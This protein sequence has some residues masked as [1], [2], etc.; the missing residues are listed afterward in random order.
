MEVFMKT[1][2]LIFA[3]FL[4]IFLAVP[5]TPCIETA[6][7]K[8]TILYDNYVYEKGLSADWG[9]SCLIEG[10]EKTILFDTGTRSD[11]LLHN[12]KQMDVNLN[13]VEQVVLSHEHGDHTGGLSTVLDKNNQVTVYAPE[14][15]SSGFFQM[16]KE[17]K[18]KAV[19]VKGP[20]ELC[21]NVLLTGEMGDRIIEQSLILDTS[22]GLIVITGCAHPG[23]VNIVRK[24]KEIIDKDIYLVFGGFHLVRTS[25]LD[26]RKIIE[27]FKDL[28]IQ[29]VGATHCT[30]DRAIEMFKVAY[31]EDYVQMGVGRILKLSY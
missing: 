20:I 23:I 9:F 19:T 18:A 13:D 22:K 6:G 31:G 4:F 5:Q 14:S 8:I 3:V 21:Q 10:M 11:I 17:K 16:V 29:K 30:G 25:E 15:F 24:S 12:V 2:L 28:G 1:I 27:T 7:I 26:V